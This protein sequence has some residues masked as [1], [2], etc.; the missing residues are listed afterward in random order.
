M[1]DDTLLLENGDLNSSSL[2]CGHLGVVVRFAIFL[3]ASF[4][5][6]EETTPSLMPKSGRK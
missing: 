3:P 1:P 6:R 2:Y 4:F 5:E